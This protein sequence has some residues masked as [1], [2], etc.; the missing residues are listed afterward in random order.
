MEV[1]LK[2]RLVGASVIIALAVI[3]IPMLF[4]NTGSNQNQSITINIPDEPEDLKNKV[5]NIDTGQFTSTAETDE[6]SIMKE[7]TIID[8]KNGLDNITPKPVINT[9]EMILDVVDSTQKTVTE[10]PSN[11]PETTVGKELVKPI[12]KQETSDQSVTIDN[13][14]Q[15]DKNSD[16]DTIIDEG[17]KTYRIK[18]GVFSKQKNAQQLKARIINSGY[19]AIVEKNDEEN[20]YFVYSQQLTTKIEAQK[21]S[22]SI[23]KINLGIGK[24]TILSLNEDESVAVEALLDTGWI[25]QIGSFSSKENSIKLRDKIRK[26]GF[27]T[28]VDEI[29]NPEKEKRYRVRVGPYATRDESQLAQGSIQKTM[30][31]KGIIK[32]HEK[33]KVVNK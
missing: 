1:V 17:L 24:P 7:E 33:Q 4:D 11:D 6:K 26:K 29:T 27:V 3:F 14:V 23:Q 30:N 12:D 8:S 21:I 13:K 5:I 32:P 20:L 18:Y 25:I 31:L 28:F 15:N 9:Q 22:D 19:S 10:D 2:Q 16:S